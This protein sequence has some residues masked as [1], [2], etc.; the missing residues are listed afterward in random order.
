MAPLAF[1]TSFDGVPGFL[2]GV[3]DVLDGV[4]GIPD[5]VPDV[6]DGVPDAPGLLLRGGGILIRTYG[7]HK[8]YVF[9]E[10]YRQYLV[11]FT[12]VPRNRRRP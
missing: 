8:T 4:P 2:D 7:T 6:L 9:R 1:V 10:F 3:P 12:T 5:G 11:L